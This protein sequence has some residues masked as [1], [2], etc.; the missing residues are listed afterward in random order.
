MKLQLNTTKIKP[1][2]ENHHL[3]EQ[4]GIEEAIIE[5]VAHFLM[6][7]Q[8]IQIHFN[9]G[10]TEEIYL[11]GETDDWYATNI[12]VKRIPLVVKL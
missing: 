1:A 10:T 11:K 7:E 2:K 9:D 3:I 8:G 6:T 12:F 4:V 5:N